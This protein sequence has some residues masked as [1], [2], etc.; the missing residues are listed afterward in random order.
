MSIPAITQFPL[1]PALGTQGEAFVGTADAFFEF[2]PD[3]VDQMNNII[4]P[5]ISD[6]ANDAA[7]DAAAQVDAFFDPD[8][9]YTKDSLDARI[10]A[11]SAANIPAT[12]AQLLGG[13]EATHPITPLILFQASAPVAT[14]D[15][16]TITLDMN[17]GWNFDIAALGGNRTLANM[18]NQKAGVGGFI[19]VRQ[20]T[21]GTARTLIYG[22][23]WKFPNGAPTLSTTSGAIDLITYLIV[24]PGL[25]LAA[26]S[27][28]FA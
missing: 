5:A 28:S 4:L 11:I 7:A 6:V 10:D 2:F 26:L 22:S 3:F 16:A 13:T 14:A 19:V 8:N 23:N 27:R 24:A 25:I 18:Q 9:Y 1:P 17:N 12:K 15:A 20:D 21:S